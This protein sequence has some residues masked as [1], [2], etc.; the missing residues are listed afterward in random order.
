MEAIDAIFFQIVNF[1]QG[2]LKEG[3][4]DDLIEPVHS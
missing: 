1:A 3:M 4:T 2:F